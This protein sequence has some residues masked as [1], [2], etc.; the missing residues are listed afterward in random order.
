M[1]IGGSDVQFLDIAFRI[2]TGMLFVTEFV[3]AVFLC[4]TGIFV[5]TQC[6]LTADLSL[7]IDFYGLTLF[8]ASG[9]NNGGVNAFSTFKPFSVSWQLI[10]SNSSDRVSSCASQLR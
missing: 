6:G 10:S 3:E 4:P 9:L 1:G 7:F 2:G 5:L 8:A